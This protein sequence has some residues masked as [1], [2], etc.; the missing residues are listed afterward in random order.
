VHV[1]AHFLQPLLVADAEALFLVD[2]E[3]P[4]VLE[5]HRLG[6][7]RVGADDDIHG[8]VG[9]ALAGALALAQP[10][11]AAQLPDADRKAPEPLGKAL[12]VLAR[13]QRRGGDHRHL[14]AAHRRHEGRAHR[15]FGLAEAD[16]ATNQPVHRLTGGDVLDHLRNRRKLVVG[17]LVREARGKLLPGVV[18]GLQHRRLAQRAFGGEPDQLVGNLPD[19]LLEPGLLGLPCAAA[20]LV[21]QPFLV[22]ELAQEFNVFDGKIQAVATGVFERQA[23]VRCA[24][25]RDRLKPGVAPDA[26]IDMHH[27]VARA[28]GIRLGEK[29]LRPPP[30]LL[31]RADQ[32]VPQNVLFRHHREP[33]SLEAVFQ[34]PDREIDPAVAL[35]HVAPVG[36]LGGGGQPLVGEQALEAVTRALRIGGDN[37]RAGFTFCPNMIGQCTEKINLFLLP[38]RR[39]VAPDPPAAVEHPRPGRTRQLGKLDHPVVGR[40]RLP[41]CVI[42]VEQPRRTGLVDGIYPALGGHRLA[43]R[44]ILVGDAVPA[45]QPRRRELVVEH[46]AG[47]GQVVEQ[48]FKPLVEERQPVLRALMLTA[49]AHRLIERIVRRARAEL[50]AVILPEPGDR[51]LV[52]DHL[53]NRG[54]LDH[55]EVFRGPL[56]HRIEAA[57]PVEHIAEQIEPH[58]PGL[59]RRVDVDDPAAHR[60]IAGLHH[61]GGLRKPHA[62]EKGFQRALV[63][64]GVDPRG[65]ARLAQHLARRHTLGCGRQGGEQ[66]EALR[67]HAVGEGRE[68]GHPGGRNVGVGRHPVIGQAIP[69][70]ECDARHI[71]REEIKRRRHL[72]HPPRIAGDMHERSTGLFQFAGNQPGVVS[73]GRAREREGAWIGHG[74]GLLLR[75]GGGINR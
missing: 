1:G 10:N 54:Q 37:H 9:D 19:A 63:D 18:R 59:A 47:V 41:A 15:H 45:R 16:I 39:E 72:G 73:L 29:V 69:R 50:D 52:E 43:P 57:R 44:V 74:L 33:C 3:Q 17:F 48:G 60:K 64:P 56:G 36:D 70:R 25:R 2:H 22:A 46:H 55:A 7:Q 24:R 62:H 26:V 23:F 35:G 68:R 27:E 65:E 12:V 20:E 30:P 49:R 6:E 51:G 8:A 28:E 13:E 40:G 31:R 71:R 38:F 75:G 58:R 14:H 11:E 61:R 4:E 42:E 66:D 34:R 67:R 21:E 5:P 32:P 53:R